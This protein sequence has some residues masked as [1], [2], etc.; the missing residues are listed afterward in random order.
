[1]PTF[2]VNDKMSPALRARVEASVTG[3]RHG[4]QSRL[5]PRSTMMLR[6]VAVTSIVATVAWLVLTKQ[7]ADQETETLRTQLVERWQRARQ[8]LSPAE[9]GLSP[10]LSAWLKPEVQHYSGDLVTE[11]ARGPQLKRLLSQPT[12]YVRGPL[13]EM[14][15]GRG[16]EQSA[17]DSVKDAFVLCLLDPPAERSEKALL[18]RAKSAYA[19]GERMQR[20][21]E[22]VSRLGDAYLGLPFLDTAWRDQVV[23]AE[24]HQELER[25]GRSFE[26]APIEAAR[27]ALKSRLL[28]FVIDEPGAPSATTELDGEKPHAVRVGLRDLVTGQLLL[29]LRRQ[30][31]PSGFSDI[32][33]AEYARGVDD[34]GLALDVQKAV[35]ES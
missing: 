25:L 4:T 2:L 28:L 9:L 7:R 11:R 18:S 34:C 1:V 17:R 29:R 19:A 5:G 23:Q 24:H 6:V 35:A 22:H 32:T 30:V 12:A 33:R 14:G 31:D 15:H 21:T 8:P 26:L 20:S 16:L 3:R 10:H 27:R 13:G